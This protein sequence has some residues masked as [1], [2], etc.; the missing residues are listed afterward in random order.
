M[1]YRIS[2]TAILFLLL[3]VISAASAVVGI[4]DGMWE[5]TTKMD[6]PGMPMEMEM[7]AVTFTQ[8]LTREN[9]VP[10][11]KDQN[12]G[13]KITHSEIRGTTVSWEM[14]CIS[15]GQTMKGIGKV[16]YKGDTFTGGMTIESDGMNMTQHLS[17]RR[18]GECK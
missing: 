12:E 11:N 7:P 6:M 16:T 9:Q 2:A 5:V 13:C 10:Q 14:Q 18:I 1:Y 15:N 4:T 17:G 8:C 3:A